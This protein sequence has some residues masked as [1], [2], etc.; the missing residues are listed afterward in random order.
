MHDYLNQFGGAERVVLELSRIWP[1]APIYT[2]LYR[3]ASTFPEYGAREIRTSF[4]DRL[5]VDE[6]FRSLAPLYP[7]A[8]RSLGTLEHDIV[9]SSSSGWSHGVRTG[10]RSVHI[11]YCYAPARWLYGHAPDH[12]PPPVPRA[13]RGVM[14]VLR[15]WDRQAARRA[16]AYIAISAN[17]RDR[18]RRAYGIEAD[19]VYPPVETD[20]FRPRP[21]GERMLVVSRLVPYKRIDLAVRAATSAGVGLD[22]VGIG[23]ELDR[24]R[25]MAGP[26]VTFHGR[27][28]DATVTALME[29]A[30]TVCVPAAEDFGLV[31]V[32]ANAAGKP[33]VAF[34][35]G[36]ATETVT[37]G[38]TGILYREQ[39]P[40]GLLDAWRR[41][42]EI[43]TSP[44][45]L[46]RAAE[47][48][49]PAA[50]RR[51]FLAAVGRA[52]RRSRPNAVWAA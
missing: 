20:R 39:S 7:A 48:F 37:D 13:A 27:P 16:D 47:F 41:A 6:R 17:V 35:A 46:A 26:T 4:L 52:M 42:D 10:P 45:D 38:V 50:F 44:M 36:G 40:E 9:I 5:P 12:S 29:R 18:I 32:E 43:D 28:D 33:V 25:R 11:V 31:P 51:R 15:R 24:L 8:F 3:R 23:P 2:S 19:V 1:A 30:R 21:R 14:A 49:S 22:V 34:A